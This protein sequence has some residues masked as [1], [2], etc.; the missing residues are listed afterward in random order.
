MD[1]FPAAVVHLPKSDNHPGTS[2]AN[3]YIHLCT[4]HGAKLE[5]IPVWHKMIKQP[6][7]RQLNNDPTRQLNEK[8]ATR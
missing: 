7:L 2:Q 4:M 3:N 1:R 5:L 6:I 8:T